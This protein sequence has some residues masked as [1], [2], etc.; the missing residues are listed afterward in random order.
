MKA[1][2]KILALVVLLFFFEGCKNEAP[3]T[4][5]QGDWELVN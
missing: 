1:I 5:I 4:A 2:F 3:C